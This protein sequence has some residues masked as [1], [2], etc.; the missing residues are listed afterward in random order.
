MKSRIVISSIIFTVLIISSSCATLFLGSKHT[1]T[2]NSHPPGATVLI[3]GKPTNKITPCVVTIS[4]RIKP[5][6]YDEFNKKNTCVYTFKKEG[7]LSYNH[8]DRSKF[9]WL[10][11]LD[12][13]LYVVPGLIDVGTGANR[14]YSKAITVTLPIDPTYDNTPPQIAIS[15][16]RLTN[17]SISV[18]NN[19]NK[20]TIEGIVIDRGG[21]SKVLV[22]NEIAHTDTKGNFSKSIILD[23]GNNSISITAIDFKQNKTTETITINRKQDNTPPVIAIYSPNV[24]RGFKSVSQQEEITIRGNVSDENGISKVLINNQIVNINANG[25]FSETVLLDI[26]NNSFTVIATDLNQNKTTK[27]FEVEHSLRQQE[28]A[29]SNKTPDDVISQIG[30]FYALIIGVEDYKDPKITDLD[31]PVSDARKL[32]NVLLKNYTFESENI[33]LLKNPTK[34]G[35]T[36][37]LD[38]YSDILTVN[39]NLLIFYAGH[40]YWDEKYK[41]GYWLA[42]DATRKRRG[43][44]LSNGII[45]D[46]MQGIQAKHSLLITDACFGGGIFKS[47]DAFSNASI[48]INQM[49]NL[50]SRKAMTS[51]ALSEVPDKSV[52]IEYLVKRLKQNTDKYLSSEQLFA[53]FKVAVINNSA[54]G[55]L[56]QF[57]EVKSTGDEGGDFIFIHK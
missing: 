2:L 39:D 4:K 57:G 19:N 11:A 52:F 9:H 40:G 21:I 46:Y 28:V 22:N 23:V 29:V 12:F 35:I 55:Q 18:D 10:T 43:T 5:K 33:K 1:A 30:K 34:R 53:S 42:S 26:G 3:N 38:N 56:P 45:R 54:N 51:G 6:I 32:Y 20:I 37:A 50:P 14:K 7:Y 8:N 31:Q 36:D 13:Y 24:T 48:A 27:N 49:Y 15:Y 41:Q 47:R 25:N 44:W 16:P 17:G